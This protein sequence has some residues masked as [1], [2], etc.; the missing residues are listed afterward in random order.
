VEDAST[1]DSAA[2]LRTCENKFPLKIFYNEQNGGLSYSRNVGLEHAQGEY[3]L[4]VDSDDTLVDGAL[5]VLHREIAKWKQSNTVID[6]A[7][8]NMKV[9]NIGQWAKGRNDIEQ[10]KDYEGA[11]EGRKLY[12]RFLQDKAYK[13]HTWR[14]L[15]RRAFLIREGLRFQEGIFHEDVLFSFQ[16]AMC[17][18]HVIDINRNLYVYR[19]RDGSICSNITLKHI[20]SFAFVYM[21]IYKYMNTHIPSG[22]DR[23]IIQDYLNDMLGW[24]EPRYM[25]FYDKWDNLLED[26]E[27]EA[28]F[29]SRLSTVMFRY[30]HLSSDEIQQL[31]KLAPIS[32][33]GAGRVA[34]ELILVCME[35]GIKVSNILVTNK[36]DNPDEIMGIPVMDKVNPGSE[37]VIAI[38]HENQVA[39]REIKKLLS[40]RGYRNYRTYKEL[41]EGNDGR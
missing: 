41:L 37:I 9:E 40:E 2:V 14:Q 32:I 1:D 30:V 24:M 26:K 13:H 11:Y 36:A 12:L 20:Q 10:Y 34:R 18:Q 7:Y 33:Y 25:L 22:E 31:G 23:T 39:I 3:I 5:E 35:Q 17:A 19:R 4:F 6:I 29:K 15:Y 16:A 27:D 28:F 8:Y 21:Q 38:N